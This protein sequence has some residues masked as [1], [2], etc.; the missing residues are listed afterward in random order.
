M[1]VP[2]SILADLSQVHRPRKLVTIRE[3]SPGNAAGTRNPWQTI[4]VDDF[5]WSEHVMIN[6]RSLGGVSSLGAGKGVGDGMSP[7]VFPS[8]R[9]SI[10]AWNATDAE[11]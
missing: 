9:R 2:P 10:P 7:I 6:G 4:E 8:H 11:Y 5:R 1:V 3:S